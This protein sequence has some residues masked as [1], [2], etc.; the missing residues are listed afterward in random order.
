RGES[1]VL[2]FADVDLISD[3]IAF[4]RNFLGLVLTANDNHKLLLNS[5]DYLMGAEELMDV[6]AKHSI[7]RPF[8]LFDEIEAA[9]EKETLE[10]ERQLRADIEAAQE[11]LNEKRLELSGRNAALFQKKLQDEVDRLNERV[12]EGN[13]ELRE[14][15]RGRREALEREEAKVR[16]AVM[17]WMPT[18]ILAV[19]IALLARRHHRRRQ[20]V[21]S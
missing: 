3:Q 13:R 10:R 9:A 11:E 4:Q 16:F 15:R 8:A 21:G 1:T 12:R 2:V 19:G 18:L 7:R 17:G 20:S 14:I 5:V 6:R